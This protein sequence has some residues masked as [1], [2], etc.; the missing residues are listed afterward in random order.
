VIL[1]HGSNT[2]VDCVDLL[3]CRP[4]KDFG[5][6]FYLTDIFTHAHQMSQR[7]VRMYGGSP[8]VSAF[9]FDKAT[10]EV[11]EINPLLFN[12]PCKEWALFVLNN[13]NKKFLKINDP[14]CNHDNKYDIVY[15]PIAN[16]DI[17]Y[18]FRTFTRGLIDIDALIKGME[19]K[20]LTS[21]YSFH[22]QK[23]LKYLS[24]VED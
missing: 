10:F 12:A 18:L 24:P 13:R 6:G 5:Q 22:T 20:E 1:Y 14:L 7:V 2:K 16:D 21:Q 4:Y 15:G 23:S 19:Y 11:D 3:K 9:K 8:F 17:V